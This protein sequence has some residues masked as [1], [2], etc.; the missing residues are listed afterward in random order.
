VQSSGVTASLRGVS[1]VSARVAW[2]SGAH[3]S[4]LRTVDGGAT[5]QR[6]PVAGADSLDF[7]SI[8]AID[9]RTA[10]VA[11]AGDGATGQARTYRTT[12]G[13]ATWTLVLADT[14]KG[15]FFDALAFWDAAHGLAVSDPVG[16]RFLVVATD[17]GGR[18][19]RRST[20]MP[21]ATAGEGA[22][23]AGGAALGVGP[24]GSAWFVTGGPNGARVYR[25]IDGAHTWSATDVPLGSRGAS[26]GL[27]GVAFRDARTGVAVGGDYTKAH[28][29]AEYVYRSSDG[30]VTWSPAAPSPATTGFWSGLALVPG[31]RPAYV[32]VGGAGTMTSTDDGATWTRVDTT[33][34][35]GVSF[36]RDGTGWAVGPRGRIV[37]WGR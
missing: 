11:S 17:D 6:R 2:A 23:A 36:A 22:F 24:A 28:E 20:T 1:A 8:R 13:G 10:F 34:L 19:W 35:N 9:A 33:E 31:S 4:V 16:G 18:T 3:N 7:R 29:A 32:A 12:D 14:T 30:G 21:D 37:R 15:A 5:W 26:I 27:F 25:S